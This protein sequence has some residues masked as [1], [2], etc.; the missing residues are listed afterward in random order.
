MQT[1]FFGLFYRAVD[2]N[3]LFTR[4]STRHHNLHRVLATGLLGLAI[5]G[6]SSLSGF[7]NANPDVDGTES[8]ASAPS[9]MPASAAPDSTP[10]Y[11]DFTPEVLYLLTSAE[12]AA[13]RG[14]YDIT[15]GHY[16]RA[17]QISRDA[18]VIERAT[19]IALSLNSDNAQQELVKLWLEVE[20]DSIEAHRSAAIQAIKS[21]DL[22]LA[23]VHMERIME[24]GGDADFD[25]LA[26]MASSLSA[27]RQQQ[28]LA[29]YLNL[30]ERQ[31][32][33]P[34]LEYSIALLMKIRDMPQPAL[35]RLHTLL[36]KHPTFQPAIILKGDLLYVSDQKRAALDH[37]MTNTRRFPG[38]RQ[39]G[40]L[41]GRMLVNEGELQAAQDEFERLV[42]RYP[43][44]SELRLSHALVAIENQQ[45]DIARKELTFLLN[46]G[47]Q[48]AEAN[49]YLGR[50]ADNENRPIQAINY[51]QAVSEGVYYL[52]A[53]ARAGTL[54]AETG[55]LDQA[56]NAIQ[57]L[58]QTNPG[59]SE[60]LWM[61]EINLLLEQGQQQQAAEAV[62]QA[63][64]QHPDNIQIRYA[65]AMMMDS[66]GNTSEAVQDLEQIVRD[67][68]NNAVALNAL[69]YILIIRTERLFEA[70]LLIERA[71]ELEPENPAILD[72]MGWLLYREGKL[73]QAL[74][75][76]SRAW[77]AFPDPEIAAHYGEVL[78]M[79]GAD[80][81]ARIIWEQGL[82]QDPQHEVLLETIERVGSQPVPNINV[83]DTKAGE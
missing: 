63:L 22:A 6:C 30:A 5:S 56:V 35:E 37:L 70:R 79:T 23:L 1:F 73:Q 59:R 71:L 52:P 28:L 48:T 11:G 38:N 74:E 62:E 68:A 20:P 24:L 39:M 10:V 82:K 18:G 55:E 54:L 64:L 8:N 14:R 13:Q 2:G 65:R 19:R 60:A 4:H 45:V 3:R 36:K 17:A 31:S 76:L 29:L 21:N 69:G 50:L 47:Q 7:G 67:D 77:T 25:S 53:Q 49:Y 61:I 42:K 75:Y 16:V 78:W 41:F 51:Y 27:E 43:D 83:V 9:S 58:R 33:N 34:E 57:R 46:R 32:D 12:I 72:S 26:A 40:A 81:Q 15:L 66:Q 80:E 44:I